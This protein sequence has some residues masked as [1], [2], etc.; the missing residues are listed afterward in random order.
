MGELS[1]Y[2]VFP[3]N[4]TRHIFIDAPWVGTR[5]STPGAD[6]SSAF[7]SVGK[8]PQENLDR[9]SEFRTWGGA[10][11][12]GVE[13]LA[14]QDEPQEEDD[15]DQATVEDE[16]EHATLEWASEGEHEEEEA[17]SASEAGVRKDARECGC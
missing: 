6:I 16:E 5:S 3:S 15:G 9:E 2:S 11:N 7:V 1:V 14:P 8:G 4:G 17:A 10:G 12:G 13:P